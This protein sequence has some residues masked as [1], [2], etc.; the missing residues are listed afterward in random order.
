MKNN[1]IKGMLILGL[2]IAALALFGSSSAW[3]QSSG[4]YTATTQSS[5]CTINTNP[6]SATPGSLSGGGTLLDTYIKTPN[7]QFT[8]LVITPSIVTGLFNNTQVTT[9][10]PSSANS[11]AVKV[12]VTMDG[13]AVPPETGGMSPNGIIYDQ[14]FQQLSAPLFSQL[15]ECTMNNNCSIDL[16]ESTLSAHS[17]NF[18]ATNVGGGNHHLVVSWA[19]VC[20]DNSGATV[21]CTTT[22]LANT[23]GACAGPGTFQIVQ[24]KAFSQSGGV[25]VQ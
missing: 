14:R 8:T 12:Y 11:A 7:S 15:M 25:T 16:V 19:F 6:T 20:T 3:A 10:M 1:T 4:N 21:P 9:A 24:T 18:V 2:V 22:Y 17:F 5:Q 13:N 23:A